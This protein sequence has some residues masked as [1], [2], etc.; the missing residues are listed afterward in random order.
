M[1]V[2]ALAAL[3]PAVCLALLWRLGRRRVPEPRER[4]LAIALASGVWIVADSEALSLLGRLDAPSVRLSWL[5]LAAALAVWVWR[6]RRVS[7]SPPKPEPDRD[8]LPTAER[9]LLLAAVAASAVLL[10]VAVLAPPNTYDSM[11]YHMTRVVHWIQDGSL[12]HFPTA[13][14]RQIQYPPF[15]ELCILHLQLLTGGDRLANLPQWLA[16]VGGA[17]G[18]SRLAGLLGAGLAGQ[19]AAA[20]FALTLPMGIAQASGTQNDLVAAFWLVALAWAVLRLRASAPGTRAWPWALAAGVSAGL[21]AATK[22]T[23]YVFAAPFALWMLVLLVQRE[24]RSAW[25]SLAVAAL[26]ALALNAGAFARNA[27]LFGSP[28]GTRA[29]R[30]LVANAAMGPRLLLSNVVRDLAVH[31]NVSWLDVRAP[32]D[33]AVRGF[34]EAIGLP[35][36]DRRISY[37]RSPGFRILKKPT[38]DNE[39]GNGFHVLVLAGALGIVGW[40]WRRR[41]LSPEVGCALLLYALA[42]VAGF[43]LFCLYLRWQWWTSRLQLPLFVLAAPLAGAALA[44]VGRRTALAVSAALLVLAWPALVDNDTRSLVGERSVLRSD[45]TALLFANRPDLLAPYLQLAAA[46][47]STGCRSIGLVA[48]YNDYEY[49]FW[50]LVEGGVERQVRFEHLAVDNEA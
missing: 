44:G 42:V 13:N 10:V 37:E 1:I 25:R 45:R 17:A 8:P 26:A 2:R 39:A 38:D 30:V 27:A 31:A 23:V 18:V 12:A 48:N 34:H 4:L 14:L 47:R 46:V 22:A 5:A 41:P 33:R 28:L 6:E 19:L 40:S 24:R 43:L 3:L 9:L 29:N 20:L 16:L 49:P 36:A 32:V 50:I 11:T 35:V 15:A 21:A 7:A